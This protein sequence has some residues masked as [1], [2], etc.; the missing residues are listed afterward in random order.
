MAPSMYMVWDEDGCL[1]GLYSDAHCAVRILQL[2]IEN[3][4]YLKVRT[5][6][7]YALITI[8]HPHWSGLHPYSVRKFKSARNQIV[9][10]SKTSEHKWV[11]IFE[12][13]RKYTCGCT[14]CRPD[15]VMRTSIKALI[16]LCS[17][18]HANENFPD[19]TKKLEFVKISSS[20]LL[21]VFTGFKQ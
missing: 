8:L 5:K 15:F 17:D 6:Y 10:K 21:M 20:I 4:F 2:S 9:A 14:N 16:K 7:P 1:K 11:V 12:F 18:S 13:L 3:T 19:N